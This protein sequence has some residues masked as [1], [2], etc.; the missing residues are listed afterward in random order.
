MLPMPRA[1]IVVAHPDDE[2]IA[3]GARLGRFQ[4]AHFIHATD[5]APRN[6]QDSRAHGFTSL[7]DYRQARATELARM[8]ATAGLARVSRSCIDIP[9]QQASL[10]LAHLTRAIAQHMAHHEPEVVFTHPYEGGHPDHD[11]CAFAVHRAVTISRGQRRRLPLIIESP[12]YNAGPQ[13]FGSGKFIPTE[14]R[15]PEVLYELS[16]QEK[17][18]KHALIDCFPTQRETLNGFNDSTE[19]Y[20]IAPRYDFT[21]P[22]HEGEVL[23]DRYPWGMQ[24]NRFCELAKQAEGDLL[25]GVGT[26]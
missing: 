3:L 26:E 2:T 7:A 22:P 18:R 13:G 8:F 10:N 4:E 15:T 20:R 19:R 23:Y 11:A 25:S 17:K 12:F 14:P 16:F 6:E 21:R 1:M 9:D 5:G 24:S